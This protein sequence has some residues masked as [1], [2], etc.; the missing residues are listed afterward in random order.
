MGDMGIASLSVGMSQIQMQQGLS[1]ATLK[2]AMESSAA[3]V[4]E[5]MADMAVHLDPN[6]GGGVDIS[7]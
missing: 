1:T 3:M 4:D 2:L 6:L 5:L 7:V